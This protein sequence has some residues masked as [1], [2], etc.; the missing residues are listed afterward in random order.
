MCCPGRHTTIKRTVS[1]AVVFLLLV[2]DIS[3][4]A[5]RI[6]PLPNRSNLS[7]PLSTEPVCE[8]ERLPGGR[9]GVTLKDTSRLRNKWGFLE[10]VYLAGDILR[11]CGEYDFERPEEL[12]SR[13]FRSRP[14]TAEALSE[15]TGIKD[16]G[17]FKAFRMCFETPGGESY[18]IKVSL[19]AP[20]LSGKDNIFV[21]RDGTKIS[22]EIE[23]GP[24]EYPGEVKFEG[25]GEPDTSESFPDGAVAEDEPDDI[26]K[27]KITPKIILSHV[28]LALVFYVVVQEVTG[29]NSLLLWP[30]TAYIFGTTLALDTCIQGFRV[31]GSP[32]GKIIKRRFSGLSVGEERTRMA[33]ERKERLK[34]YFESLKK[35]DPLYGRYPIFF[36][37]RDIF[38]DKLDGKLF[39]G[40]K[41]HLA[42]NEDFLEGPF[43]E[44]RFRALYRHASHE[45]Y[46]NERDYKRFSA[47]LLARV[48]EYSSGNLL[49]GALVFIP[50]LVAA[51]VNTLYGKLAPGFMSYA[52]HAGKSYAVLGS[53]FV[54]VEIFTAFLKATLLPLSGAWIAQGMPVLG[55][56]G[57]FACTF[58]GG[59]LREVAAIVFYAA[60]PGL[61]LGKVLFTAW[62][63]YVGFYFSLPMQ[64]LDAGIGD[65]RRMNKI[66]N[67]VIDS[68]NRSQL[69]H[70]KK[71]IVRKQAFP[72]AREIFSYEEKNNIRFRIRK[73]SHSPEKIE[74][75]LIM[76]ERPVLLVGEA[77]TVEKTL[78][79][80]KVAPFLL[81]Q[82]FVLV[83]KEDKTY[84]VERASE[85]IARRNGDVLTR[86]QTTSENF[87]STAPDGTVRLSFT[88]NMGRM[89]GRQLDLV[90]SQAGVSKASVVKQVIFVRDRAHEKQVR[91]R[92]KAYYGDLPATSFVYQSPLGGDVSVEIAA[93]SSGQARVTRISD[94]I[95]VVEK[96][97]VKEAHVSGIRPAWWDRDPYRQVQKAFKEAESLLSAAGFD[98]ADDVK[99]IWLYQKNITGSYLFFSE[100]YQRLNDG[101][102]VFFTEQKMKGRGW[103]PASTG[104]GMSNGSMLL[105]CLAVKGDKEDLTFKPLE[106]PESTNAHEYDKEKVL[107]KGVHKTSKPPL[108]SRGISVI[109]GKHS[110]I[111]IS[112]TASVKGPHVVHPG[113]VEKQTSTTIENIGIVL[114][115]G[116]AELKDITQLRVYIKNPEDF[117]KVKAIVEAEFPHAPPTVYLHA[118]VCRDGWL[119]EIEA[120]ADRIFSSAESMPSGE[121]SGSSGREDREGEPRA[122]P[123]DKRPASSITEAELEK[124]IS[125]GVF[126]MTVDGYVDNLRG[127]EKNV[128]DR[129]VLDVGTGLGQMALWAEKAGA[130][131][132]TGLDINPEAVNAARRLSVERKTRVKFENKDVFSVSLKEKNMEVITAAFFWEFVPE[133]RKEELLKEFFDA[134]PPGGSVFFVV[135]NDG[136]YGRGKDSMPALLSRPQGAIPGEPWSHHNWKRGLKEA[137]F[138]EIETR[139]IWEEPVGEADQKSVMSVVT[140]RKKGDLEK[141]KYRKEIIHAQNFRTAAGY[142]QGK[143]LDTAVCRGQAPGRRIIAVGR[144]W[145]KSY[146]PGSYQHSAFNPLVSA[147]KN[148]CEGIG[149]PFIIADDEDLP[150]LI[151]REREKRNMPEDTKV[152]MLAGARADGEIPDILEELSRNKLYTVVGV[153]SSKM[154]PGGYIRI[155]EILTIALWLSMGVH[156]DPENENME[157]LPP[158]SLRPIYVIVPHSA[159]MDYGILKFIYS[160]QRYA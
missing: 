118:D 69:E 37:G 100:R 97:G 73:D 48:F 12:L 65:M 148:Y 89:T 96:N 64:V 139:Y 78:S 106:N 74:N 150:W 24:A 25:T 56:A 42:I 38:P 94:K 72:I 140:A 111:Y 87:P 5:G 68:A 108:F 79:G 93:E 43:L 154:H 123:S 59:V 40:K 49:I 11:L 102:D 155:M 45:M 3:Y 125:N 128:A 80:L 16:S 126:D 35:R 88:V 8:V 158:D 77:D 116:E 58:A 131:E 91:K 62:I 86:D 107:K 23:N 39:F 36:A 142:M 63:P 10:G 46:L 47:E 137:G 70:A 105:E 44:A 71:V 159:P 99:R 92:L 9:Y 147:I 114:S 29:L 82:T 67:K 135:S 90:L 119:V 146:F 1:L 109:K 113:D 117:Q 98:F 21:L 26:A 124:I 30:L 85:W 152:I 145:L 28:F 27:L 2:N 127:Y 133:E 51:R 84:G 144:S 81:G 61:P 41:K 141:E 18:F 101:R 134:L 151:S 153:D 53:I 57:L 120:V 112:G 7:A 132:I 33:E 55:T 103:Y 50:S 115:R 143:S 149:V 20:G 156:P 19:A 6:F 76:G 104:I 31:F 129:R 14:G 130:I 15:I 138:E 60:Q 4:G 95:T 17:K 32:L 136:V 110:R 122:L 52:A 75:S 34:E 160:I 22:V 157:I 121:D 13:L 66:A 54:G 83:V